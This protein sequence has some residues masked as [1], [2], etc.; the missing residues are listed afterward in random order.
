[1]LTRSCVVNCFDRNG[2]ICLPATIPDTL[3]FLFNKFPAMD[4][5]L[6]ILLACYTLN[7]SW[8]WQNSMT[9][10]LRVPLFLVNASFVGA[11][12]ILNFLFPLPLFV[13]AQMDIEIPCFS[14]FFSKKKDKKGGCLLKFGAIVWVHT[15]YCALLRKKSNW[16]WKYIFILIKKYAYEIYL[17]LSHVI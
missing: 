5:L 12:L 14:F 3:S 8:G 7:P 15:N 4:W 6:V 11:T 10:F 17:L 2:R 9:V 16:G 13:C 1:M